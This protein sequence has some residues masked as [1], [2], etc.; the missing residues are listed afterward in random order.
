MIGGNSKFKLGDRDLKKIDGLKV[1]EGSGEGD[2]YIDL[3]CWVI[4]IFNIIGILGG[5]FLIGYIINLYYKRITGNKTPD[6]KYRKSEL[7][8]DLLELT[9]RELINRAKAMG[10]KMEK[11]NAAGYAKDMKSSLI[12]LILAHEISVPGYSLG[13]TILSV[14]CILF[15]IFIQI[16]IIYIFYTTCSSQDSLD[17][18]KWVYSDFI[19][20]FLY[21]IG[22]IIDGLADGK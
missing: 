13:G 4:I 3:A 19:I 14:I 16:M 15:I 11:I 18:R 22:E 21:M 9:P 1:I 17:I 7:R 10:I 2:V 6:N 12:D 5:F 20:D 8:A